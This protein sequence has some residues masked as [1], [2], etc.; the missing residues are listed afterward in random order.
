MASPAGSSADKGK[1]VR[2]QDDTSLD[3]RCKIC[4]HKKKDVQAVN[5]CVRC[6]NLN[7]CQDCTE[8]HG[9]NKATRD[10]IL[11]NLRP[12]ETM[13]KRHDSLLNSYCNE[14]AIA[15]CMVCVNLE[16]GDHTI[17]NLEDTVEK[18][19][20]ALK[21]ILEEKQAKMNAV[22]D[23]KYKL[24]AIQEIASKRDK[25]DTLVKE[26]EDHAEVCIS[27]I[28]KWKED[29]KTQVKTFYKTNREIPVTLE[30]VSKTIGKLQ[31]PLQRASTLLSTNEC[32]Q[33]Q[34]D[35]LAA[36]QKEL[37][38]LSDAG[39]DI[40]G[41]LR[42]NRPHEL[43]LYNCSFVPE[44]VT[45]CLGKVVSSEVNFLDTE[46]QD[47]TE[48]FKYI[49]EDSSNNTFIPCV[50]NL[51]QKFAVT[52]PTRGEPAVAIDIFEFPGTLKRTFK[53][54]VPPLYDMSST[55]DGKLAV[56]SNGTGGTGCSVKLFDP[57][58]G[59]ISSTRDIDITEPLSLGVTLQHQYVIL[60]GNEEGQKILTVV[61]KDGN[62]KLKH[63][64]EGVKRP[65]RVSCGGSIIYVV[66]DSIAYFEITGG[67][68]HQITQAGNLPEHH[69]I[70]I[71][72][73]IW[74]DVFLIYRLGNVL[75]LAK[76][77][78]DK[79]VNELFR[80][81]WLCTHKTEADKE[82][83]IS[84]RDGHIVWSHG[85]TVQVFAFKYE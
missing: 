80:G 22:T 70:D 64:I 59:Y 30:K 24:M 63:E 33:G 78:V 66:G 82:A 37:E 58:A 16:H 27:Q 21:V 15:V 13:C 48:I 18:K 4:H 5:L 7:I 41:L 36:Q 19:R 76:W 11:V 74:D 17:E 42:Q 29:L 26:I 62:L 53:D 57:D 28:V 6:G 40:D 55:P 50:A 10:H 61:D 79:H 38:A 43:P 14:C 68:I 51:G 34:I 84:V 8:V 44:Q 73:T 12:G 81:A 72:A 54:H 23:L 3:V 47:Q 1:E 25:Q 65:R 77:K 49:Y 46:K 20:N 71:S 60:E 35:K 45:S 9:R 31:V 52:K 75:K 83:R 39:D 32:H 85:Q 69:Y 67:E 2:E 56:L